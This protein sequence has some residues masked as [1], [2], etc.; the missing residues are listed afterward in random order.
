[1]MAMGAYTPIDGFMGEADWRGVCLD[2][3]LENGIFGLIPITLS[4]VP[5]LYIRPEQARG[6]F[7]ANGWSR[8]AAFQI[9]NPMQRAHEHLA[10]NQ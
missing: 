7:E 1:M 9:R 6:M 2:M 3:K 5:D 8:V 4:C 10:E